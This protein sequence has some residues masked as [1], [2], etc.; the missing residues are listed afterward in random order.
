MS[1]RVDKG[2][3]NDIAICKTH[4]FGA[5]KLKI[6]GSPF[7]EKDKKYQVR[8]CRLVILALKN[9]ESSRLNSDAY[10]RPGWTTLDTVPQNKR[11]R[12]RDTQREGDRE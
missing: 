10:S 8:V 6:Q 4:Y 2:H 7:P 5:N 12:G 9:I 11:S 3:C 1:F